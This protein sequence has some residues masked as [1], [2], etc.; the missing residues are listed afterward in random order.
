MVFVSQISVLSVHQLCCEH[1]TE[2]TGINAPAS[3]LRHLSA[4]LEPHHLWRTG[5]LG[6]ISP[7]T[8]PVHIR[9]W[10]GLE[11]DWLHEVIPLWPLSDGPLLRC[12]LQSV[13]TEEADLVLAQASEAGDTGGVGEPGPRLRHL[14]AGGPQA[15]PWGRG[16]GLT[17]WVSNRSPGSKNHLQWRHKLEQKDWLNEYEILIFSLF[18]NQA[19]FNVPFLSFEHTA[20]F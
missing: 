16:G 15:P 13:P 5:G 4:R 3:L 8:L 2:N 19:H 14:E 12:F 1:S 18:E 11:A 20:L 10:R 6:D 9:G 7:L 17:H